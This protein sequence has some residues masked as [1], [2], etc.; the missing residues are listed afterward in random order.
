MPRSTSCDTTLFRSRLVC[1]VLTIAVALLPSAVAAQDRDKP[2]GSVYSSYGFGTFVRGGV[3][4]AD[5]ESETNITS[6]YGTIGIMTPFREF[7]GFRLVL[8]GEALFQRQRVDSFNPDGAFLTDYQR[9]AFAALFGARME[10][11]ALGSL[12]PYASL[13]IGPGYIEAVPQIVNDEEV[14][15]QDAIDGSLQVA[16]G[17]RTGLEYRF[18]E[19]F[20][21]EA[22]YRYL[23]FT[24]NP[25]A[26][27]H[28]VELGITQRF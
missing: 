19:G 18:A 15:L 24:T 2:F 12:V 13:G 14:I 5:L 20:A 7:G 22:G 9:W 1:A 10:Y 16:Y 11:V 8:E 17:A 6:P 23:G 3:S 4:F 26:G 28:S 21:V 27:L 25:T